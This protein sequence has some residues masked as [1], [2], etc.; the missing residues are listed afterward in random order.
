MSRTECGVLRKVPCFLESDWSCTGTSQIKPLHMPSHPDPPIFGLN[1]DFPTAV[2]EQNNHQEPPT[3][4]GKCQ[5]PHES[6]EL[7]KPPAAYRS[8]FA[9]MVGSMETMASSVVRREMVVFLKDTPS[10]CSHPW[11]S[12]PGAHPGIGASHEMGAR[13]HKHTST[14]DGPTQ[15]AERRC[16]QDMTFHL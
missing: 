6:K 16:P 2:N 15:R 12:H 11:H 9:G 1:S 5:R 10:Q 3:C 4:A 14:R 13:K 8:E 7:T